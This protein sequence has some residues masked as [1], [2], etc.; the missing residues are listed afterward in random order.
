MYMKNLFI[1][2]ATIQKQREWK[3]FARTL[4]PF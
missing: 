1:T 4:L 3:V 2:E